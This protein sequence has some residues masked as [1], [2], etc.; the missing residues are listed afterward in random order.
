MTTAQMVTA[1]TTRLAFI[2]LPPFLFF[3]LDGK[4]RKT[5]HETLSTA[6]DPGI[7]GSVAQQNA[8]GGGNRKGRNQVGS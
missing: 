7:D 2:C 3:A 8:H 1:Q 4:I 5:V 6:M